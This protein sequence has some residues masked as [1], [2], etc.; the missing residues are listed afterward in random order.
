MQV[1]VT[2][3]TDRP[4]DEKALV[5]PAHTVSGYGHIY[6]LGRAGVPVTSVETGK[7]SRFRSR[8]VR[9]ALVSP[10][11]DTAPDAFIEW[12]VAYGKGQ[13][14]RSVLFMAEDRYAYLASV[15]REQL[16]PYFDY[17]YIDRDA[18][19]TFFSK[20]S[21]YEAARHAGFDVPVTVY[22]PLSATRVSDL[23]YP[24]VV[25]PLISRFSVGAHGVLD[26]ATFP[27]LYG[28]KALLVESPREVLARADDLARN[29]IGFCVQ[30]FVPGENVNIAN[31][32]M[33]ADRDHEVPACF[34]SRKIRQQPAD[35]G[36]CSVA[37]AEVI[38]ELEQLVRAFVKATEYTGPCCFEFKRSE[39]DRRWYFIEMNPRLDYFVVMATLNGVNLPLQQ[40]LLSTDRPLKPFRQRR[41]APYWI[42]LPGDVQGFRWRRQH[43]GWPIGLGEFL[44][45]YVWFHEA[46]LRAADPRPGLRRLRSWLRR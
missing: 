21:M 28:G 40:Y 45:P 26:T 23:R 6:S 32:K 17:P 29:G 34:T 20:D 38:P 30:E 41:R 7:A 5:Y 15:Y 44:R 8:Y 37:R 24:V 14:R 25:K 42:D 11:P 46:S 19:P 31:V 4:F 1:Q 18:L 9:E 13:T 27:E 33:V 22:S 10:N 16:E 12:L 36:T 3:P 2:N 43:P 39:R 35:F